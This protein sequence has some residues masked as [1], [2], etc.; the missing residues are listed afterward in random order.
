MGMVGWGSQEI[1]PGVGGVGTGVVVRGSTELYFLSWIL[2]C[3]RYGT[4]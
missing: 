1:G 4:F 2:F 3:K